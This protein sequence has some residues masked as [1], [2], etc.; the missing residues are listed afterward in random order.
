MNKEKYTKIATKFCEDNPDSVI[1]QVGELSHPGISDLDFLIIDD[2]PVLCDDV[3]NMLCGGNV[4]IM[5]HEYFYYINNLEKFNLIKLQGN[6]DVKFAKQSKYFPYVE[7]IEWLYERYCKLKSFKGTDRELLLLLKSAERSII[8]IEAMHKVSFKR[9][10]TDYVR[11]NWKKINLNEIKKQ[12]IDI[13][14]KCCILFE[15]KFKL[16]DGEVKGDFNISKY[17]KGNNKI[18]L[19]YFYYLSTINC[20]LT[21]ALIKKNKIE[22]NNFYIDKDFQEYIKKRWLI[23]SKIYEWF[24]KNNI[25]KGIIKYGWFL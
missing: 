16:I 3:R 2:I 7:I 6:I 17:Y 19:L 11:R 5:P 14:K 1:Y 12:Y 13:L 23:L 18:M 10:R 21:Q 15:K 22:V 24:L 20:K 25:K 8:K 4:I 9:K